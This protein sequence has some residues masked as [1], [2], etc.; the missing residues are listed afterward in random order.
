MLWIVSSL[1][2]FS[3]NF[4]TY[5]NFVLFSAYEYIVR[6]QQNFLNTNNSNKRVVFNIDFGGIFCSS[7]FQ[8]FVSGSL[9]KNNGTNY[10]EGNIFD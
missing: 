10:P 4:S 1:E 5:L 9:I 8:N 2:N 7:K 6:A 3:F